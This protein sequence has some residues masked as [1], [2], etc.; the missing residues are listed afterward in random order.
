MTRHIAV[1]I[2]LLAGII[3]AG[4]DES[5]VAPPPELLKN[6]QPAEAATSRPTT[7]QLLEG[8]RKPLA[9]AAMPLTVRVPVG[10]SIRNMD[11]TSVTFLEGPTPAG[12]AS[13]QL[14]ERA[15][16]KADKF[17]IVV[18]GAKRELAEHPDTIRMAELRD[19]A[20]AK[21]LERQRVG[22]LTNPN[23]TEPGEKA[24][25]PFTWTITVFVPR[26]ADYETYELNFIG[27]TVDQYEADKS[28]LRGI[29]DSL[30]VS[31]AGATTSPSVAQ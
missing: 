28:L 1:A 7:Q 5:P 23:L 11:G 12:D 27:L 9:L 3:V 30:T 19:I 16:T 22:R 20:G 15:V 6:P 29:I 2:A 14:S 10:W 25:P 18:N 8:P 13:I 21:V 26:G 24:S 4:C 17:D 31:G